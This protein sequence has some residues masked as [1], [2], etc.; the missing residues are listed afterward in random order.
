MNNERRKKPVNFFFQSKITRRYLLLTMSDVHF[1][2][3]S[4]TVSSVQCTGLRI[5][6]IRFYHSFKIH[7][8]I[9]GLSVNSFKN[10]MKIHLFMKY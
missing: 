1:I 5:I 4:D 6:L 10:I 9:H 7:P 8:I 2:V 3:Y